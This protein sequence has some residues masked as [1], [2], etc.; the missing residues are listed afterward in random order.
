[1]T[2]RKA[3]SGKKVVELRGYTSSYL[4]YFEI[5]FETMD[6]VQQALFTVL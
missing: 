6:Q 5:P 4:A 2:Q 1:M 3:N